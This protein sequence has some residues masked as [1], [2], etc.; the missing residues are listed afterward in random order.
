MTTL[1]ELH[2]KRFIWFDPENMQP[3]G[4]NTTGAVDACNFFTGGE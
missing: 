2:G 3:E 1:Q 4:E